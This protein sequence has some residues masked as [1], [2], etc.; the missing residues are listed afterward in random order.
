MHFGPCIDV[1]GFI[2]DK[3]VAIGNL[4]YDWIIYMQSSIN[5][6]WIEYVEP[7]RVRVVFVM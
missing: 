4:V 1:K 3:D 2:L 5:F 6:M 7:S